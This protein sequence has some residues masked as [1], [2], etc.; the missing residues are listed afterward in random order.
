MTGS[1]SIQ[2]TAD[3]EWFG[4]QVRPPSCAQ[5][6]KESSYIHCRAFKAANAMNL[7]LIMFTMTYDVGHSLC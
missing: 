3:Q 4:V 6:C 2:H 7:W 5:A 1:E